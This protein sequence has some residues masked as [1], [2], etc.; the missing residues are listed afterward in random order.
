M[1]VLAQLSGQ[2]LCPQFCTN[3]RIVRHSQGHECACRSSVHNS[4]GLGL[5]AI[6]L[7]LRWL[8]TPHVMTAEKFTW[9]L[10]QSFQIIHC[11]RSLQATHSKQWCPLGV[12]VRHLHGRHAAQSHADGCSPGLQGTD[13]QQTMLTVA[14]SVSVLSLSL[15]LSLALTHTHTPP[16]SRH[17]MQQYLRLRHQV[18]H[19][20]CTA[21]C[22]S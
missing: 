4:A 22:Q 10:A 3:S 8:P 5:E 1:T 12:Q 6:R 17:L 20:H 13:S 11:G 19:T 16:L 18:N 2:L 9:D 21:C 7:Y 15:S 14:S